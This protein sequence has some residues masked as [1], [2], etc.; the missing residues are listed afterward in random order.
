MFSSFEWFN[1]H[2]R[3]VIIVRE[4]LNNFSFTI[5]FHKCG[6][7]SNKVWQ[8]RYPVSSNLGAAVRVSP[9]PYQFQDI[10][11]SPVLVGL[12]LADNVI[13]FEVIDTKSDQWEP[14]ISLKTPIEPHLS[15]FIIDYTK[16]E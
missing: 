5:E 4:S 13:T 12:S 10:S 3:R 2:L 1:E 15:Y 6:E 9:F 11:S 7:K 14:L 8:A 16:L